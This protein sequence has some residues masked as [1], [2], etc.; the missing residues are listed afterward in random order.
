VIAVDSSKGV[1]GNSG[2]YSAFVKVQL[3]DGTLYC[4]ADMANDR[5]TI[6]I[7]DLAVDLAVAWN[8]HYL[9]IEQ[10]FGGQALLAMIA[11]SAA[12]RNLLVPVE[13]I[14][15]ESCSKRVR[16]QRL[17]P[18]LQQRKL[19]FKSDSPGAKLLVRQLEEFPLGE[20]DDGPD[21]LEMA[22][23]LLREKCGLE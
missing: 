1:G 9:G 5:N 19:R 4:D 10:E 20:H 2:D 17:S 8:V 16:I 15:T 12:R 6:T 18:Y 13:G 7:A 11:S 22:V 3:L 14:T 23:R 21:A